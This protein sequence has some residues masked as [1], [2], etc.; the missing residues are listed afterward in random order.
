MMYAGRLITTVNRFLAPRS[1]AGSDNILILGS[2]TQTAAP[3]GARPLEMFRTPFKTAAATRDL[4]F[5]R[6]TEAS[7]S[8]VTNTHESHPNSASKPGHESQQDSTSMPNQKS[9]R[10]SAS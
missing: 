2:L 9:Q 10:D 1:P 4:I 3:H 6:T 8:R 5:T 7:L